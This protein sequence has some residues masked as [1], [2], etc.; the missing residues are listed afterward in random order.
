MHLLEHFPDADIEVFIVWTDVLA[1]DGLEGAREAG[2]IFE[3][4]RVTLL[5]DSGRVAGRALAT[6]VGLTDMEAIVEAMGGDRTKL[7][8]YF[9]GDFL[10]GPP[11]LFDSLFFYS[12]EA[13]WKDAPPYPEDWLTQ[14]APTVYVGIEPGRFF[15][16]REFYAE[17]ERRAA[18]WLKE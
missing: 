5:H 8:P 7:A 3:D 1:P 12:P 18:K 2:Q 15:W 17:I 6:E 4:E 13:E 11:T 16:E 14:L 10:D 9:K